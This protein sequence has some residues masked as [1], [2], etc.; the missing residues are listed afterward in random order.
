MANGV[1]APAAAPPR[2]AVVLA[3]FAAYG[4]LWG[5]Y[6]A[7]MPQIRAATGADSGQLGLALLVGAIAA[8]LPMA[9][10]GR[11]LDRFGRA[12]AVPALASFGVVAVLPLLAGSLPALV[13]S[14]ALF[15]IGSGAYNVAIVALASTVES[16]GRTKVLAKAHG[17]FSVGVLLVSTG[18]GL[19]GTVGVSPVAV[20]GALS[21][22]VVVWAFAVRRAVPRRT[23]APPRPGRRRV[24]PSLL[25]CLL[26]GLAMV[27]E[28]GVQQWSAIALRDL[29]ATSL[30]IA[31]AAPGVF[32]AAMAGGR[33]SGH[34][35]TTR[36]RERTVLLAAGACAGT[37]VLLVATAG[38]PVAALAGVAVTGA[39]ISLVTPVSYGLAGRGAPPG[40]RGAVLG[41]TA[42]LANVG[43]LLGPAL[44]GQLSGVAGLR[45]AL[46]GL[47]PIS[48]V[49][50]V[51]ATRIGPVP[52]RERTTT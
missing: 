15:G 38:S 6:L 7:A 12:A 14:L 45:T 11:L 22:A 50:C 18:T 26:A 52:H 13:V 41:A 2:T 46:L 20:S 30:A 31:A 23:A 48:A 32:A 9:V 19:A 25:L 8:I 42:S 5:P 4:A 39:G 34:R 33:L 10:V 47:I 24:R 3:G 35:L 49:V 29:T 16:D 37:G 27:V 40:T 28:S 43:L 1:L 51:L 36:F 17:L 21:A 44:V